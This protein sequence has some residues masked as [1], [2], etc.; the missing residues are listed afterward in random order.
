[1]P[2]GPVQTGDRLTAENINRWLEFNARGDRKSLR[3]LQA[4]L[5][6][7]SGGQE[8]QRVPCVNVGD[9][10]IPAGALLSLE[11]IVSS[12]V[13]D[14][15]NSPAFQ[16][17]LLEDATASPAVGAVAT[18]KIEY[19]SS[20]ECYVSGM[21]VARLTNDN[22]G[23]AG[24]AGLAI[25]WQGATSGDRWGLVRFGGGTASLKQVRILYGQTLTSGVN[26]IKY[27]ASVTPAA[28]YDPAVDTS[29]PA[30]LG[31]GYLYLD[32]VVQDDLVLVRHDFA[33]DQAPLLSGRVL[34]V[35]GTETL[36]YSGTDMTAYRLGWA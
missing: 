12:D 21:C 2:V 31:N 19:R 36:T 23:L 27:A 33:G 13:S 22:A 18:N 24:A 3:A 5:S 11:D 34:L 1:M 26:V 29:Y 6:L 25:L 8:A 30:G 7:F 9:V 20:G 4:A 28:V 35:V 15:V 14:V 32:G 17:R 16:V 10:D